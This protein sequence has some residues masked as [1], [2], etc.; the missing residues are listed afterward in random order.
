MLGRRGGRKAQDV[1]SLCLLPGAQRPHPSPSCAPQ[2]GGLAHQGL[3]YSSSME[4][5]ERFSTLVPR[6]ASLG[7]GPLRWRR[8]G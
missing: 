5:W 4:T 3:L 8:P 1:L 7:P 2:G 6:P